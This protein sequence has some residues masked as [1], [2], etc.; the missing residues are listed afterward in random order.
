M[1]LN[2]QLKR[3][4]LTQVFISISIDSKKYNLIELGSRIFSNNDTIFDT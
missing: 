2:S 4:V 3:A 1:N